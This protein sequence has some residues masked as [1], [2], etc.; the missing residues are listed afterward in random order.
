MKRGFLFFA[1]CIIAATLVLSAAAGS[2]SASDYTIA[3]GDVLEIVVWGEPDLQK[4]ELTV[5]RDGKISFPLAGDVE[6]AGKTPEE[7][8]K[9]VE[10]ALEPYIPQAS[11][12]VIISQAGS[13]QYS[14]L[15]QVLRPG[16]YNAAMDV[17]VLQALALAGGLTPFGKESDIIIVRQQ[18]AKNISLP[19]RYDQVKNG[20]NLDQNII[21]QRGD[22]VIV[23]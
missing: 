9:L 20:K 21:L 15:G 6:V 3:P 14:V 8:R 13:L 4:S 18:D 10:A 16:M 2:C 17:T 12:T 11:A 22:V 23:P 7:V 1:A 5:R 19:F